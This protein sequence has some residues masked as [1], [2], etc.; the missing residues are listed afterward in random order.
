M[1]NWVWLFRSWKCWCWCVL[2]I[3]DLNMLVYWECVGCLFVGNC[4]GYGICVCLLRFFVFIVLWFVC[5]VR[6]LIMWKINWRCW[7]FFWVGIIFCSILLII[8]LY[9][10]LL[11]CGFVVGLMFCVIWFGICLFFLIIMVC[12]WC[13]GC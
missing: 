4:C 3:L 9:F 8:L 13:L 10:W 2:M 5:C 7:K 12:C 11:L 6:R 1:L